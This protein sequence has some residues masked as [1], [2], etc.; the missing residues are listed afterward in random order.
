M[1]TVALVGINAR[2]NH[3][4]LAIRYLARYAKKN[5]PEINFSLQE[6]VINQPI[7]DIVR[8]LKEVQAPLVLFSVYIWNREILFKVIRELK[9]VSPTTLIGVGGPEVSYTS[10]SILCSESAV[11]FVVIGEGEKTVSDLVE[12]FF[13]QG[14]ITKADIPGLAYRNPEN[15]EEIL[16]T[17]TRDLVNL[18]DLPFPYEQFLPENE[19]LG[20][21]DKVD[22]ANRIFYYE[23]SRG[24]P[25]S[26][27]Y[28]LSS[29]DKKVRFS[30]IKK[31]FKELDY[32]L[33]AQV[34]LVKFVDRTF[35][36]NEERYL[37]IWKHIL[38]HH[39]QKTMFHFEIAAEQ[40]SE[41]VLDFLQGIPEGIMQFEVGIQSTNQA[42]LA[43]IGRSAHLEKLTHIITRIPKTIHTHL[44]LI[45]GLPHES[46]A[47]FKNS[48]NFVLALKPDMLQLGFLKILSGTQM[49]T[50][51]LQSKNT[52]QAYQWLSHPPYE[53]IQSPDMTFEDLCFLKDVEQLLDA[54]Y[55]AGNFFY[56][57]N[58]IF[59]FIT[60]GGSFTFFD[61]FAKLV[62]YFREKRLFENALS[63]K[64]YFSCLLDFFAETESDF[65]TDWKFPKDFLEGIRD[66]VRFDFI[67]SMKVGKF[68]EW[69][70]RRYSK[71]AHHQALLCHTKI[72]STREAYSF[73]DY[74]EFSYN[75]LTVK[76]E[77]CKFLF[78]YAKK[79]EKKNS[80][81]MLL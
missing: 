5:N 31:V 64:T 6:Y 63:T 73:S 40:F 4:N 77:P 66:F 81:F 11:D 24:C 10:E 44:D 79:D 17:A 53:V 37:A 35:N 9:K 7:L 32:F 72:T 55:N 69:Y 21:Q 19:Q 14:C 75:P 42:T 39:N 76:K 80:S 67:R 51:A 25:F 49:E 1:N 56:T 47:A 38:E 29:V 12:F 74:E 20:I 50:F 68:P 70:T 60:Q 28:C 23:S 22:V 46:L 34:P 65:I 41:K 36:L 30:S 59:S 26:C 13:T 57:I 33:E 58:S 27:S 16:K 18:D 3:T 2:Y 71:D 52:K 45:A 78:L 62:V 61:F 43:E 48:F 54:Y 15:P 8:S